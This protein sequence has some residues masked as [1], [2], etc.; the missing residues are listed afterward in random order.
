MTSY[1]GKDLGPF[2][3]L[4]ASETTLKQKCVIFQRVFFRNLLTSVFF[5]GFQRTNDDAQ[6]SDFEKNTFWKTRFCFK[7]V[8]KSGFWAND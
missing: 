5:K 6:R 7:V 2:P 1:F 8:S 4:S 3:L